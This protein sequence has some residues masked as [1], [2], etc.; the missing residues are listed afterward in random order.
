MKSSDVEL[1]QRILSGDEAAFASLIGKYQK[2]VHVHALRKIGDFHIAED[3]TQEAFLEVYQR[4]ETLEEPA[5]FPKWLYTIVD[6]LCIAWFRKNRIR[7]ESLEETHISEIETEAYSR[8]VATEHAKMTSEAQRDLVKTLLTK[9]KE[10]DQEVITLHYFEEMSS[11]EIG[12][13]LGVSENTIKSRLRRARQRLKKY[14]FMIQETL[15]ITIEDG[16]RSQ[17]QLKGAITVTDEVRDNTE[18]EAYEEKTQRQIADLQQQIKM[19]AAESDAFLASRRNEA[20]ETLRRVPY[21]AERPISWGYVGGYRTSPGKMSGRVAF[22][23]DNIDNFL[24]K[25][26]DADIVNLASLFTNPTIIAVL[27][28]LVEGKRSVS[29]LANG[30][31]L[32][33]SEVEKA[34]ETLLDATL[35]ARTEDNLIEPKNDVV[36]F[37]LNFVSMTIVHLGHIKPEN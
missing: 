20:L 17:N 6:R 9:L 11:S 25:A 12:D 19:I 2:P 10:S 23:A 37:F 8:Y 31:D 18:V 35:V 29:D 15:D 3:I 16:H 36:S 5:L 21:D 27:R 7:T 30:C 1:I 4:L 14:E 33:E 34:V 26:P 22:W 32:S 24:S 13:F 28:Q